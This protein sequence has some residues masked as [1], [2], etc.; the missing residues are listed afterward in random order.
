MLCTGLTALLVPPAYRSVV[1]ALDLGFIQVGVSKRPSGWVWQEVY[2][3]RSHPVLFF[4]HLGTWAAMPAV[5][6]LVA[7]ACWVQSLV[8]FAGG[9]S[10]VAART[11]RKLLV[12]ML[13]GVAVASGYWLLLFFGLRAFGPFLSG[14]P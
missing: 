12:C 5:F 3:M 7:L 14:S 13:V 1:S 6:A 10:A 4:L 8:G 11:L 2:E 9:P